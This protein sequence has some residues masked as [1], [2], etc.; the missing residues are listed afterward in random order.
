[1]A[2]SLA[3][4]ALREVRVSGLAL[5]RQ[6]GLAWRPGRWFGPA[7]R[8]LVEAFLETYGMVDDW[9]SATAAA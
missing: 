9:R 7:V 4:G 1:M 8:A 6:I 2:E 5:S 3:G